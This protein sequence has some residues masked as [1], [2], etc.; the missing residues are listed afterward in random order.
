MVSPSLASRCC[1]ALAG[2]LAV[3]A[4]GCGGN[5]S[6]GVCTTDLD[7]QTTLVCVA[8]P[9]LDVARCM[10]P[11]DE[12]TRL[13]DDGLVCTPLAGGRACYPGGRIGFG[14]PCTANLECES[15][16]VCPAAIGRCTQ[17]CD[18]VAS[19]C[20]VTERCVDDAT[21]GAHCGP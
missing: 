19:V 5:G 12:A 7:C 6:G 2:V 15:G 20:L 14:E 3:I 18:H 8:D 4:L 10:R 13:C 9:A 16:T 11:C 21:V 1:V 17:A